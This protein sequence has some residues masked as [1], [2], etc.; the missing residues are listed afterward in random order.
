M[1]TATLTTVAAFA[2]AA[3]ACNNNTGNDVSTDVNL[4]ED[5][6]ANDVLGA[7]QMGSAAA[8]APTDAAGFANAAAST[9]LYEIESARLAADKAR[10]SEV[11]SLAQHI[12]TDHEKSTS[13]LKSAAS[14][15]NITV[16]PKL[17]AEKQGMLEQLR[18]ASGAEFDRLYLEQQ[19]TAHQKA[20]ALLQGYS[21]GGDN[22]ALKVFAT[23]TAAAIKGHLDHANSIRL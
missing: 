12:R 3:A 21:S 10:N 8:A 11:K 14:T 15:A 19:K 23:K 13:E 2:L 6:A 5:A 16:D 20:L 4:A 1:R 22:E 17:D 9:D 18:A 7:N